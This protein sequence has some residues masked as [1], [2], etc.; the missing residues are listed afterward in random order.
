MAHKDCQYASTKSIKI[1]FSRT[2][3]VKWHLFVTI[4]V[5]IVTSF[6]FPWEIFRIALSLFGPTKLYICDYTIPKW[7]SWMDSVNGKCKHSVS[8]DCLPR[9]IL[10]PLRYA[11]TQLGTKPHRFCIT[12]VCT[13][14]N[15]W[16][17]VATLTLHLQLILWS[18][19]TYYPLSF[20]KT[21][22]LLTC[23]RL[24]FRCGVSLIG[25]FNQ[26]CWMCLQE[27]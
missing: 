8:M 22:G 6:F 20:T 9:Y 3:I 2:K 18:Y 4:F 5:F 12:Y 13:S 1:N 7:K 23:L 16:F 14:I 24:Y 19:S 11:L 15:I 21:I 25:S 27:L 17:E 26:F 10:M